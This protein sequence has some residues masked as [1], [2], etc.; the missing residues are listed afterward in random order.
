MP[1]PKQATSKD[2][3]R[4]AEEQV[5]ATTPEE[6]QQMISETAYYLA[7]QRNF[8][9]ECQLHDWLEAEAKINHTHGPAI[10]LK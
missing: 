2:S 4:I 5:T 3:L 7:E 9:G 6:R 10:S 8:E 1:K